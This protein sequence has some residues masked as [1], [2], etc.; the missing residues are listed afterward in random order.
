VRL[1][2]LRRPRRALLRTRVLVGVLLVTL[3]V[4]AA[5]DVA[6]VV[7]LRS[8]LINQT[9]SQLREVIDL[10]RFTSLDRTGTNVPGPGSRAS[11]R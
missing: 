9:D 2:L 11:F 3:A 8:Y 4:L 7:A 1:R 5:F 10:Y 6:G